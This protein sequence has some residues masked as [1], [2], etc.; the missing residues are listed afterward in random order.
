MLLHEQLSVILT[1]MVKASFLKLCQLYFQFIECTFKHLFIGSPCSSQQDHCQV[2]LT[3]IYSEEL[4]FHTNSAKKNVL[5]P[6]SISPHCFR[7]F[8]LEVDLS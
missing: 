6:V 2:S 3:P 4:V 7:T 5:V 1:N 8:T